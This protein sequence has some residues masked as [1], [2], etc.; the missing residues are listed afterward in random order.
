MSWRGKNQLRLIKGII[1]A[2]VA[3]ECGTEAQED[4][5][6]V[7]TC[8][9]VLRQVPYP[10]HRKPTAI[11]LEDSYLVDTYLYTDSLVQASSYRCQGL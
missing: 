9:K 11:K 8:N 2:E 1:T 3:L 6:P 5:I 7:T 10:S 4:D